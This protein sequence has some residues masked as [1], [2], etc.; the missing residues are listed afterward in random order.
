MTEDYYVLREAEKA[1]QLNEEEIADLLFQLD[2]MHDIVSKTVDAR[3]KAQAEL[4]K[5]RAEHTR[6]ITELGFEFRRAETAEA[7]SRDW[8]GVAEC[9]RERESKAEEEIERLRSFLRADDAEVRR[10]RRELSET[11]ARAASWWAAAKDLVRARDF[12]MDQ[13]EK[14]FDRAEKARETLGEFKAALRTLGGER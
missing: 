5:L 10:V 2:E 4:E 11:K 3:I 13:Y 6:T 14:Q 8:E 12:W 9:A 1:N 7:E